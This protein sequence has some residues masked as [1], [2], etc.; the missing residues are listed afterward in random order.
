MSQKID[1]AFTTAMLAANLDVD[2]VHGNGVWSYWNGTAYV[3]KMGPYTPTAGREYIELTVFPAGKSVQ[4]LATTDEAVGAF[5]AIVRYPSDTGTFAAVELAEAVLGVLKIGTILTYSGQRV[6]I[7]NNERSQGVSDGSFYLIT[8]RA[9]YR[10]YT[11][12]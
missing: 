6:H 8:V 9:L 3:T 10:A 2:L 7:T 1:Q 12:R 5:Q 11:P 4:S